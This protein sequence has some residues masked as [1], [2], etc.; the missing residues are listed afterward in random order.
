MHTKSRNFNKT[1]WIL[2]PFRYYSYY[3]GQATVGFDKK[4]HVNATQLS[5]HALFILFTCKDRKNVN[6]QFIRSFLVEW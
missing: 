3:E 2:D 6:N 4:K 1:A 5:F